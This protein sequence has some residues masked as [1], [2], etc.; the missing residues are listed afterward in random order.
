MNIKSLFKI[1]KEEPKDKRK[2]IKVEKVDDTIA[3]FIKEAERTAL[4]VDERV[5][6]GKFSEMSSELDDATN[7][8]ISREQYVFE[9]PE[10]KPIII[11]AI[12][13]FV[14]ILVFIPY[15]KT[16]IKILSLSEEFS[17]AGRSYIEGVLGVILVNGFVV[18]KSIV[19]VLFLLRYDKYQ[20]NLRFHDIEMIDDLDNYVSENEALV[21]KD[22]NKAIKWKLIPQGHFG[23]DNIVFMVSD[24]IYNK[25][26]E[27]QA[28]YDHYYRKLLEER[29]RMSE[30]SHKIQKILDRG[31]KYID[32]IHDSNDIIKDKVISQKLDRMEEVV[33]MIFYEVDINPEQADD[34][35]TFLTYYL[36]TTQKL[37][38]AYIDIDEKK[39]VG[40]SA[41]KAK[42]EI[43]GSLDIII[44]SFEG[45][46]DK[47]YQEQEMDIANEISAMEIMMKQES[48]V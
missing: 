43:E 2:S 18:Y 22:L 24:E 38:D 42:K 19:D 12:V 39:V 31:Q 34:L 5:S 41:E 10:I 17:N 4:I 1:K 3:N 11:R 29:A 33:K 16:G 21:V 15:L 47:F 28:V 9:R 20:K 23:T 35:G 30:R 32:S 36:P 45:I 14:L 46:L 8:G 7:N 40:K 25:Y 48:Q 13:C 37:L 6:D 27:H 44:A 26:L